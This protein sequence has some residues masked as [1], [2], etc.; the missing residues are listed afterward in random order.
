M[1]ITMPTSYPLVAS[2]FASGAKT[3][4]IGFVKPDLESL[5]PIKTILTVHPYNFHEAMYLI[6]A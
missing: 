6:L 4:I 2:M 3:L 5:L 1:P